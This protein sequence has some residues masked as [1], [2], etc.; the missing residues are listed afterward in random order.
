MKTTVN[1]T[2][3]QRNIFLTAI[4]LLCSAVGYPCSTSFKKSDNKLATLS[5]IIQ[6]AGLPCIVPEGADTEE[7]PCANCLAPG[8]FAED[9]F[10]YFNDFEGNIYQM[11][12]QYGDS[13][14]ANGYIS[15]EYGYHY[16]N[17]ISLESPQTDSQETVSI[18]PQSDMPAYNMLG[19]PVSDSYKGI[20]IR[21]GRKEL[22][23]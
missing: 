11:Q 10:Y 22:W 18:D 12:L 17:L 19:I 4:L 7:Y 6:Y 21:N 20:V 16:I 3:K 2:R 1:Q 23:K 9:I 15:E 8:I 5:G 13:A 14:V